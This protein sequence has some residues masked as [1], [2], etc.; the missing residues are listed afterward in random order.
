MNIIN[1]I[2]RSNSDAVH[3]GLTFLCD[4]LKEDGIVAN[5][6]ATPEEAEPGAILLLHDP[7]D[8]DKIPQGCRVLGQRCL[9]R[10]ERLILAERCGLP[11][12]SW[13]A[14]DTIADIPKLF[15]RWGV[16][17]FLF[18]ADWSYSRGGIKYL[19]REDWRPFNPGRFNPDADI[20][21][22]ILNG[23]PDTHKIDLFYDQ[24]IAC[25]H[26][27]TRSVFDKK[28]YKSFSQRSELGKMPLINEGLEQLGKTLLFY[29][30]GFSG[31][32]VMYDKY[33]HPWIIELNTSSLG[34]EDTWK[35]WPEHYLSGYLSGLRH[36]ISRDC[37]ANFCTGISPQAA[38]LDARSGGKFPIAT[39]RTEAKKRISAEME[40]LIDGIS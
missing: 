27:Y 7:V 23:N 13:S 29:G 38:Q 14:V 6:Y 36:W 10:R 39:L 22:R 37:P 18:K 24:P 5:W 33:N 15:D 8:E 32:D 21:M 28:F 1:F 35:R 3:R 19:S 17:D 20:F 12:V 11:V 9:N 31:V 2:D 34:R 40:D 4:K 30:Q 25:R 16:D 26:M